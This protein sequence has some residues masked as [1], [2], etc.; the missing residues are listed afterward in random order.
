VGLAPVQP[1]RAG[2]RQQ[3]VRRE[4]AGVVLQQPIKP[5]GSRRDLQGLLAERAIGIDRLGLSAEEL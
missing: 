5:L 4:Q 1:G 3:L 2:G